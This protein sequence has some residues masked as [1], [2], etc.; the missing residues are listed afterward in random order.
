MKSKR[1]LPGVL[2]AAS[3]AGLCPAFAA[4]APA[5]AAATTAVTPTAGDAVSGC[6]LANPG[7]DKEAGNWLIV[8]KTYDSN[9]YST[10]NEITPDNAAGMKLAFAVPL[11]GLEPSSFGIGALEGTVLAQ[12]GFL[13]A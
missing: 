12:D 5:P 6:R 13:Y 1:L 7:T 11:N 4:Q 8:N 10:L 2:L 9:R 3:I